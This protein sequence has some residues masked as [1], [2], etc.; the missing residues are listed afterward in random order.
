MKRILAIFLLIA[1]PASAAGPLFMSLPPYTGALVSPG[2][3]SPALSGDGGTDYAF[4]TM[5]VQSPNAAYNSYY[6]VYGLALSMNNGGGTAYSMYPLGVALTQTAAGTS[7]GSGGAIWVNYVGGNFTTGDGS[8]MQ[9]AVSA[10]NASLTN[11]TKG[12]QFYSFG[13]FP[14]QN[15]IQF[16]NA[17]GNAAGHFA[18]AVCYQVHGHGTITDTAY[19]TDFDVTV[20]TVAYNEG[21]S[22]YGTYWSGET[23]FSTKEYAGPSFSV[24]PTVTSFNSRIAIT[25]SAAGTP[26]IAPEGTGA[27]PATNAN[28]QLAG[29]G[30]GAV[31]LL[32]PAMLPVYTV[33]G[34]PTCNAGITNAYASVSDATAPT[35]NAA[36]TGGGAVRI[37]VFCNGT[38]WSAH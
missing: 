24:G 5:P 23:F 30:T 32:S 28:L 20:G 33:A 25:G 2:V 7:G 4:A 13:T 22:P 37:P 17:Q 1:G 27:T 35:Y 3:M 11:Y 18:C 16:L 14:A 26:K 29:L 12:L 36:L 9:V 38:A 21:T 31:T 19:I 15:A 10:N 34:L 6:S 8:A